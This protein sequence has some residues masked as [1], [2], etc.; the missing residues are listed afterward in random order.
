MALDALDAT[1]GPDFD[2]YTGLKEVRAQM[3]CPHCGEPRPRIVFFN[4]DEHGREVTL[5]ESI[6][7]TEQGAQAT[8]RR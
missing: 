7:S 1:F 2:L 8:G 3:Y 5:D 4:P 6:T